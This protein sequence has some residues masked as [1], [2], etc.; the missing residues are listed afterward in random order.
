MRTGA[1]KPLIWLLLALPAI[2]MLWRLSH[3]ELPLNLEHPSGE[4]AVRLL[5]LA[6][7]PGPLAE[8]LGKNAVLRI[9]LARR[10]NVGVAAFL[11][12]LLHLAFYMLDVQTFR[13]L[14]DEL[15][16]PGIWTGWL[17]IALMVLPAAISLDAALRILGRRW[18][19]IQYLVYAVLAL[20]FAHWLLLD[21]SWRPA[22]LHLI[23]LALA[24]S[25]RAWHR[26]RRPPLQRSLT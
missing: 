26:G 3:G 13:A 22:V 24:W 7:L 11:Y 23:P 1:L 5:I 10:R 25:A 18:Q 8:V 21:W 14:I 15:S 2:W 4:T 19:Q 9:W 16:L 17:A 12:A 6:L 20:T